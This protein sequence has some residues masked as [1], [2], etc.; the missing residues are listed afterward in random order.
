M[1]S[2]FQVMCQF[3]FY[4]EPCSRKM[5]MCDWVSCEVQDIG[6]KLRPQ[7]ESRSA[8]W[9]RCQFQIL[10]STFWVEMWVC[11]HLIACGHGN[12][13]VRVCAHA[14]MYILKTNYLNLLTYGAEPFLRSCQLC[15][16]SRTSQ[17]FMEPEGSLPC[18]QE[19][20]SGPYPEPDW[21][22]P[23]HPIPSYLSKIYLNIVHPPTSWSVMKLLIM[24]FSPTSC[25]FIS[26]RTVVTR[27]PPNMDQLSEYFKNSVQRSQAKT[28][29]KIWS[30]YVVNVK[31]NCRLRCDAI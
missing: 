3:F 28:W 9:G 12:I 14:H 4:V 22:S 23:Y 24:H 10:L 20:S 19:P 29:C 18:S 26:L 8:F 15:S 21:S 30:L 2:V 6:P 11:L 1:R 16:Y 13:N 27:D 31:N 5:T 7:I 17:H 25:H